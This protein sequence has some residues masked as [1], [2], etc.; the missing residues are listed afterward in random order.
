MVGVGLTLALLVEWNALYRTRAWAY[1][2]RMITIL[3]VGVLP[4]LQ[5]VVL[6][7]VTFLLIRWLWTIRNRNRKINVECQ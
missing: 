1:N 6:R 5:M 7:P 3:G 4:A 2:E